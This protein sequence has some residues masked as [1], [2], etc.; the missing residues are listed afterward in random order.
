MSNTQASPSKSHTVVERTVFDVDTTKMGAEIYLPK[1]CQETVDFILKAVKAIFDQDGMLVPSII[2]SKNNDLK[3]FGLHVN[4]FNT[5]KNYVAQ[6]RDEA[7]KDCSD[8]SVSLLP[9][10]I[11]LNKEGLSLKDMLAKCGSS[12][13]YPENV[14]ALY[15][16]VET[17][18]ALYV[19][20]IV[21]LP[22]E[23]HKKKGNLKKLLGI[24]PI[25]LILEQLP[26]SSWE[27][28][29]R[30]NFIN[31]IRFFKK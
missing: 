6:V 26:W 8:F 2:L 3:F 14:D 12:S 5:I 23:G 15:L 20:K 16:Q 17:R 22:K 25:F 19:S 11:L 29:S 4:S 10:K 13:A 27:F 7:Q 31:E 9:G 21:V 1:E 18:T 24:R 30:E 28:F